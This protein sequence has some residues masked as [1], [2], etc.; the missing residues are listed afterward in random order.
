MRIGRRSSRRTCHDEV[1]PA[2]R[3][4][5]AYAFDVKVGGIL[6]VEEDRAVVG[7]IWILSSELKLHKAT[8]C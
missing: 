3:A 8:N 1:R 6:G 5:E 7:V 2:G 4:C